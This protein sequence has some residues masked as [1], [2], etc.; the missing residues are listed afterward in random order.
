MIGIN[1]QGIEFI[2]KLEGFRAKPYKDLAG[3]KTI[4]YGH[5]E[6]LGRL[7]I[8]DNMV[9]NEREGSEILY[10][11]V[12]FFER[13]IQKHYIDYDKLSVNKRTALVSFIYNLGETNFKT[14]TL[15]KRLKENRFDCVPIEMMRFCMSNKNFVK[16]LLDRRLKEAYYFI[17]EYNE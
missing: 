13:I 2:K 4:G 7:R 12:L 11:D 1:K 16:G 8:P 17:G 6:L 5:T 14:S 10:D 9:I 3:V 15:L